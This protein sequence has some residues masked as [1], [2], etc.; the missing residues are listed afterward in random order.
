MSDAPTTT[1]VKH[2]RTGRD[3]AL[4]LLVLMI[5]VV[6]IVAMVRLRGGDDVVAIDPSPTIA[7]AREANLFPVAAPQGL[8]A[9]WSPIRST[10]VRS[11]GVGTLRVGYVTPSGAGVQ[12]VESNEDPATLLVRELGD[13]VRP[14]GVVTVNGAAWTSSSGV[15]GEQ[16]ALV[17]T[18]AKRTVIVVGPATVGEL[19][20]LASAL[21]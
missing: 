1:T 3:M 7:Q 6:A 5:P 10:F 18:T 8:S 16:R 15:R 4:S 9:D 20:E 2:S 19:T 17:D 21:R 13:Q 12:L 14:A 11:G